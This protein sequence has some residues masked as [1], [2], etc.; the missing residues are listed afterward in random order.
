MS[1]TNVE[2][3]LMRIAEQQQELLSEL[4]TQ[5]ETAAAKP[6]KDLWDKLMAVAPIF[7][8]CIMASIGAYFTY[9]YNLQQL[10]VQ[11]I[12]T[13][14]KFIPH[15]VG[16]E[17]S[18]R[19]AILAISSMG[20][21]TL[22]AKVAKMFASEGTASALRSIAQT[23]DSKDQDMIRE[24]LVKTL[25]VLAEKTRQESAEKGE[26]A[27]TA[28]NAA[29]KPSRSDYARASNPIEIIELPNAQA[30][31]RTAVEPVHTKQPE[32][33]TDTHDSVESNEAD[34]QHARNAVAE[35]AHSKQ[36]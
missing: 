3:L 14:E 2:E 20:N 27:T 33:H 11:E 18:K 34:N 36:Q 29:M 4:R 7:A 30:S 9:S 23:S 1:N 8:A 28:V 17:K 12:Q 6:R 16:D 24:A 5:R 35:S 21:A 25:D 15:L 13:V 26:G 31:E 32:P 19:A 22:A 10:H